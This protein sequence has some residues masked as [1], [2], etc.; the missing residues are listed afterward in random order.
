LPRLRQHGDG[1]P[2]RRLR[3]HRPDASDDTRGAQTGAM[4]RQGAPGHAGRGPLRVRPHH[5]QRPGRGREDHLRGGGP[6]ARREA[7]RRDHGGRPPARTRD[8]ARR[9]RLRRRGPRQPR[10]QPRK[11]ARG[12]PARPVQTAGRAGT[13]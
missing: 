10:G 1:R 8:P 13:V 2:R 9:R 6:Q 11:T 4:D 3:H 5:P 12:R 7:E